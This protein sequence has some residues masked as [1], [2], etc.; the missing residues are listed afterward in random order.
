MKQAQKVSVRT[1]N[2]QEKGRR[3]TGRGTARK[4]HLPACRGVLI[5]FIE[6][7]QGQELHRS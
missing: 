2:G 1:G 3:D 6:A 7:Q 5:L 4:V